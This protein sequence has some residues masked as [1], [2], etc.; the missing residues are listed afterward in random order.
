M[1]LLAALL[2]VA[3]GGDPALPPPTDAGVIPVDAEDPFRDTDQ[4][5]ICDFREPAFRT[6][7][8]R[9]D[10][11]GDG[12]DD[13]V[14]LENGYSP[15]RAGAPRPEQLVF[16]NREPGAT[17]SVSEVIRLTGEGGDYRGTLDAI[18]DGDLDALPYFDLVLALG[19]EPEGNVSQVVR[20]EGAFIAVN[21]RTFLVFE[22]T[23]RYPDEEEPEACARAVPFDL[24]VKDESEAQ[25]VARREYTLILAPPGQT[26]GNLD[27][28]PRT[29]CF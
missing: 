27:W 12:L 18:Q 24:R 16:L 8:R 4:D 3:C 22:A 21:G 17:A 9:A 2:S 23:F 14:E 7:P 15:T 25:L 5:G 26:L 28:C 1:G 20:E 29:S 19:A 13:R 10:T 6:D 11:D